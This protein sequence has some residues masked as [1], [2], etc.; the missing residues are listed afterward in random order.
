MDECEKRL[1]ERDLTIQRLQEE[2]EKARRAFLAI[3]EE[4]KRIEEELRLHRVHLEELVKQRTEELVEANIELRARSEELEAFNK[5]MI[6]REV[7]VIELKEEV[8]ALRRLR[9]EPEA[10]PPIWREDGR[11][12]K[13]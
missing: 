2:A 13:P 4:Q 1:R 7:R 9:N 8:N 6:A 3:L 12:E 10:Y 11:M 5:A